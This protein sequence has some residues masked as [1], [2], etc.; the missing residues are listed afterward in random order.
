MTDAPTVHAWP[1]GRATRT[2][3]CGLTPFDIGQGDR[4]TMDPTQVTC[5]TRPPGAQLTY[6]EA[7][8]VLT[9]YATDGQDTGQVWPLVL[10]ARAVAAAAGDHAERAYAVGRVNEAARTVLGSPPRPSKRYSELPSQPPA[11]GVH[12]PD[13]DT[14]PP[15]PPAPDHV[16]VAAADIR[17]VLDVL[18]VD[19]GWEDESIG[20]PVKV[21]RI[22]LAPATFADLEAAADRLANPQH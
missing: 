18:H 11:V 15:P 19:Y 17:T 16:T 8:Q 5:D 20:T 13:G 1:E 22:V 7:V 3:C 14:G 2:P 12:R 4:L 21:R 9:H 6:A 10:S